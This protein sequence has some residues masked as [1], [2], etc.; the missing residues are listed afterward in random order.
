MLGHF[1]RDALTL[2]GV[3]AELADFL[4]NLEQARSTLEE[5]LERMYT[6]ITYKKNYL[7][8]VTATR[9]YHPY[10]K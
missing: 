7:F 2:S 3:P 6:T 9:I 8:L 5:F 1:I 10:F 4:F